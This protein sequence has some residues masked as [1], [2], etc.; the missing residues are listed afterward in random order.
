VLLSWPRPYPENRTCLASRPRSRR[1]ASRRVRRGTSHARA[2]PDHAR[3]LHVHWPEWML[4]DASRA[5]ATPG[6][7]VRRARA[8]GAGSRLRLAWTAHNLLGTTIRTPTLR[9]LRA[10]A[11]SRR[12]TWCS[13]LSSAE[14]DVRTSG[15]AAV[16]PSRRTSLRGRL[17][18]CAAGT[19][20]V[21]RSGTRLEKPWCSPS[22]RSSHIRASIGWQRRSCG[23]RRRPRAARC[24]SCQRSRRG[25]SASQAV[26]AISC[27]RR[28]RV[29]SARARADALRRG[30]RPRVRVQVVL[31]VG[32]RD[33][34]SLVWHSVARSG[35]SPSRSVRR[36]AFFVECPSRGARSRVASHR[37]ARPSAREAARAC[38]LRHTWSD[39][40][41]TMVLAMFD[42]P[43]VRA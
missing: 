36:R 34:R 11:G 20:R 13:A 8:H 18:G 2:R 6:R 3:W 4:T 15:S 33:A 14:Q 5:R 39:V 43:A 21:A 28:D 38:A 9:G 25:R 37:A 31:Y 32:H 16:S 42:D 19:S 24:R 41:R 10:C 17:P 27:A 40:A 1:R 22:V 26:A 23:T 29:R 7:V 35:R 12:A 30:G